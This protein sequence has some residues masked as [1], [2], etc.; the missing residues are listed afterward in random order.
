MTSLQAPQ[1]FIQADYCQSHQLLTE[2][3]FWTPAQSYRL[4]S[5]TAGYYRPLVDGSF[6]TIGRSSSCSIIFPDKTISRQHALLIS[7]ASRDFFVTD[8]MSRNGSFVN[9][10]PVAQPLRLCDGDR[11]KIGKIEVEFL[12]PE[13]TAESYRRQQ[14]QRRV[15]MIQ[16]SITQ[17]RIWQEILTCQQITFTWEKAA[18]DWQELI[19][20]LAAQAAEFPDLLMVDTTAL[21]AETYNFCRWCADHYPDLRVILTYADRTEILDMEQQWAIRQGAFAVFPAFDEHHLLANMVETVTKVN[22]VLQALELRPI[23]ESSLASVLLLISTFA[24]SE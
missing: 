17:A 11:L 8:L 10:K 13:K 6:W 9:G 1:L 4:F 7:T 3:G 24:L 22:C 2:S 18:Q 23:Q 20:Q 19:D 12:F 14:R 5:N 21:K 15:L 16:P